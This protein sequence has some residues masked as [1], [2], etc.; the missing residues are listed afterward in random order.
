MPFNI[1]NNSMRLK[2]KEYQFC[3]IHDLTAISL[4]AVFG[5]NTPFYGIFECT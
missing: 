3:G 1:R 2:I 5:N 4:T